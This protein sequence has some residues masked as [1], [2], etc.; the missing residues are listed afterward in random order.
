M[1]TS[2]ME[3]IGYE[4]GIR[5]AIHS[6]EKSLDNPALNILTPKQSLGILLASLRM[7]IQ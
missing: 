2:E 7:E 6:I 3:K 5:F 1:A 4:N